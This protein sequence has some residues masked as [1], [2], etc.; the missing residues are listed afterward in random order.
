MATIKDV[1]KLAGVSTATVSRIINGKGEASEETIM[2]VNK[3]IKEL[4]YKPSSIA[5]TLS[6]KQSNMI[7]LLI[8]TLSN[9]FFGELVDCIETAAQNK[10]YNI[11]LCDSQD[12]RDKVN[13]YIDTMIDHYVVGSIF[14][15][16]QV[17]K[18]DLK[19]LEDRGIH[20]ITIDRSQFEHPYTNIKVN[21]LYGGY[22]ATKHLI[23][24]GCKD[25][26]F[27]SGPEDENSSIERYN[28]YLLALKEKHIVI[29]DKLV[30]NFS[31]ES[32]YL[33]MQNYIKYGKKFDAVFCAND[34]MALGVMAALKDASIKVCHDVKIVGYDNTNYSKY[35]N[36]RLT[37][38]SQCKEKI[39]EIVIDELNRI[40]K[41]GK[42]MNQIVIEPELI[43][44]ESSIEK[45]R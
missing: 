11:L 43:I 19:R 36:P 33:E 38:V 7:A 6:K 5:K 44:R 32:G 21:N 26:I 45:E 17:T 42:K 30:G 14:N 41:G 37:T 13:Y 16:L 10:G 29:G 25:I 2:R 3:V 9:P 23:D 18:E 15:S 40:N 8:P 31:M 22:I 20:T 4:N 34:A 39:G 24:Q 27:F 12:N 1:A 28:G 35:S